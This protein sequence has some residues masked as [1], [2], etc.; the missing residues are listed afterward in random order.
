MRKSWVSSIIDKF[1]EV[2][3]LLGNK[4]MWACNRANLGKVTHIT[5]LFSDSFQ[6]KTTFE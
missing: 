1:L 6:L 5:A 3:E 2:V 4:I